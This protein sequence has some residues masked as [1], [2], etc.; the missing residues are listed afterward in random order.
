MAYMMRDMFEAEFRQEG[1]PAKASIID[2]PAEEFYGKGR[3]QAALFVLSGTVAPF[4]VSPD[5][6]RRCA[7]CI[8]LALDFRLR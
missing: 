5:R 7:D 2:V 6:I 4:P 3:C 8:M 1:D